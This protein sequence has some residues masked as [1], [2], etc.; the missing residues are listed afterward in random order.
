MSNPSKSDV[1]AIVANKFGSTAQVHSDN[2]SLRIILPQ[3]INI[4]KACDATSYSKGNTTIEDYGRSHV[5]QVTVQDSPE[6]CA[7][8]IGFDS[9][10]PSK[11]V[12]SKLKSILPEGSGISFHEKISIERERHNIPR[13]P[14]EY[15]LQPYIT[16]N[17]GAVVT[18]PFTELYSAPKRRM[19]IEQLKN[20]IDSMGQSHGGRIH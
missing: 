16:R 10:Q 2:K 11:E 12:L 5:T 20:T 18:I 6:E 7:A 4:K 1:V 9:L 13:F 17:L 8:K 19:I 14:N 15:T 3:V